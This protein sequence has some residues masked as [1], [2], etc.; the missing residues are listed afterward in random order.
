MSVVG[1]WQEIEQGLPERWT[2]ARLRLTV[3]DAGD[4][5]RAASLLGPAIPGRRGKVI[6]FHVARRG[7][8]PSEGLVRRLLERVDRGKIDGTLELV[9][10]DEAAE[11]AVEERRSFAAAWDA[12]LAALPEDWS[13][14]YAEVELFSSDYLDRAALLLAPV[15]PAR[16]GGRLAFRFRAAR[17][18][19]YGVSTEMG[20]RCLE[21]L[22]AEGTRGTV[23]VLWALSD[24]KPVQTQGPVWYAGGKS[25]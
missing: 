21:R 23:R 7:P 19:G 2:D 14:L 18:F 15:N 17:R 12:A 10:M 9:G 24:T 5:D 13:D 22:D 16:V 20:R 11:A 3:T 8:G 6:S 4:C 25:V 1:Q